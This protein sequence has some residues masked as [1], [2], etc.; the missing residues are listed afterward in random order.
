MVDMP[1]SLA[2]MKT[3][4]LH[5]SLGVTVLAIFLVRFIWRRWGEITPTPLPAPVLAQWLARAVHALLYLAMVAVP[6]SGW[7]YNSAAGFPLQIFGLFNLPHLVAA[8]PQIKPIAHAAHMVA[9][10]SML[11]LVGLHVA[12]ALRHHFIDRDATLTRMLGF[13]SEVWTKD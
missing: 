4:A 13:G 12:G 2:K 6:L 9:I 5:K 7:W 1:L 11:G 8:D 10:W 3:Y